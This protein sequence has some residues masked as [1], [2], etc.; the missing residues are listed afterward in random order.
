MYE[1]IIQQNV[2]LEQKDEL[3][4]EKETDKIVK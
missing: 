1:K 3:L 4:E 2:K